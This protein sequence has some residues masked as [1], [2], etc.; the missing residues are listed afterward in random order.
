MEIRVCDW[1]R[2]RPRL[3]TVGL[4]AH[5][6]PQTTG[7][8][9]RIDQVASVCAW[10]VAARPLACCSQVVPRLHAQPTGS[11]D[12]GLSA[13]CSTV[14]LLVSTDVRNGVSERPI[15]NFPQGPRSPKQR[16]REAE[17]VSHPGCRD[18]QS[19]PHV[20][21]TT[22][23]TLFLP[24]LQPSHLAARFRQ[25]LFSFARFWLRCHTR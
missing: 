12:H 14:S 8:K 24:P 15:P 3:R 5:H 1:H 19:K 22:A 16:P 10:L 20:S 23:G 4:H 18:R 11:A 17:N 21:S 7:V 9:T 2:G 13:L 6:R 25:E